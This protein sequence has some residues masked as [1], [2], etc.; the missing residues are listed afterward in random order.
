MVSDKRPAYAQP[1]PIQ[2]GDLGCLMNMAGKLQREGSAIQVCK[3]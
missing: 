2:A 1:V 3:S